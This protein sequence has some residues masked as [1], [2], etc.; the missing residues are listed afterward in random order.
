MINNNRRHLLE[1][2]SIDTYTYTREHTREHRYMIRLRRWYDVTDHRC[3]VPTTVTTVATP[4]PLPI[5]LSSGAR[6]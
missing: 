1:R 3:N 4:P 6:F 5:L 2:T